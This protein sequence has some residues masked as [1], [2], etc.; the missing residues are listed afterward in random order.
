VPE[1]PDEKSK[2]PDDQRRYNKKKKQPEPTMLFS[3]SALSH[4]GLAVPSPFPL[5]EGEDGSKIRER[6]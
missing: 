1:K 5:P 2:N 6:V 3:S 4:L